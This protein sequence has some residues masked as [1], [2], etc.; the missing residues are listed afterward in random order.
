M[1]GANL[2][3]TKLVDYLTRLESRATTWAEAESVA[4]DELA[5]AVRAL[6]HAAY[7]QKAIE[8]LDEQA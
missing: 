1:Q 5:R 3:P 2:T 6:T 4:A 7:E 8:V